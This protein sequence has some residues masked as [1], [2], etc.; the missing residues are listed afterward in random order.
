MAVKPE[1]LSYN[2]IRGIAKDFLDKYNP[3]DAIPVDIDEIAEFKLGIEILPTTGIEL[4]LDTDAYLT[5]DRKQIYIDKH[6]FRYQEQ[7]SRF[8]IAE[9]IG[10]SILHEK[11]YKSTN[12]KPK[13]DF[14]EFHAN[15][16]TQDNDWYEFQAKS[17]A[18]LV[19]VPRNHLNKMFQET[20]QMFL[21]EGHELGDID[22]DLIVESASNY[23]CRR[24]N[25]SAM[26]TKIRIDKDNLKFS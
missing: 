19:L 8:S 20:K 16:S 15:L 6:I 14:K 10:H 26:T 25:V 1:I 5:G 9:E 3:N 24:F 7:R 23:I 17:F 13:E 18:G 22:N 12:I 11:L 21:D 4:F 2:D